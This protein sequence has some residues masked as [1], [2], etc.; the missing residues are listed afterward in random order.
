VSEFHLSGAGYRYGKAWW[1]AAYVAQLAKS[2]RVIVYSSNPER[3]KEMIRHHAGGAWPIGAK[4][5]HP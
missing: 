3:T 2:R 5:V 1:Q 4:V